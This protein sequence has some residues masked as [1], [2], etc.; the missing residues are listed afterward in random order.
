MFRS[1]ANHTSFRFE[2]YN[3]LYVKKQQQRDLHCLDLEEH[4]PGELLLSPQ[5]W[6]ECQDKVGSICVR[7]DGCHEK[8]DW[9]T[10]LVLGTTTTTEDFLTAPLISTRHRQEG[11]NRRVNEKDRS[12]NK[13]IL[14]PGCRLASILQQVSGLLLL[15]RK[16]RQSEERRKVHNLYKQDEE[17][18][19]SS[20]FG[21]ITG[22]TTLRVQVGKECHQLIRNDDR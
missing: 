10:A 17:T 20:N 16:H 21:S 11:D 18:K 22:K 8:N 15:P 1:Q 9:N 3:N 2:N 5:D 19:L 13:S 12:R 6:P 14:G 7:K 4:A